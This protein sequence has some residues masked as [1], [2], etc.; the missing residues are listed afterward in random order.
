MLCVCPG[1]VCPCGVFPLSGLVS[2]GEMCDQ[3]KR[4]F[5]L[6]DEKRIKKRAK[7]NC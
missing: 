1:D 2:K 4:L 6:T 3:V 7:T 5:D